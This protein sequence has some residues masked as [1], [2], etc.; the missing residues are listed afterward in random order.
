MIA[1]SI[2]MPSVVASLVYFATDILEPGVIRHTEGNRISLGEP[3]GSRSA[4]CRKIA[5]ALIKAGLR[6]R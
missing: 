6:C 2:A 3:D 4:R 1:D 5:E